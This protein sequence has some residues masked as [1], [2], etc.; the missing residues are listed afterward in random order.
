MTTGKNRLHDI[1]GEQTKRQRA[2]DVALID[3]MMTDQIP[4]RF[5]LT[6]FQLR[7]PVMSLGNGV[8]QS[9]IRR[10]WSLGVIGE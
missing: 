6:G 7:E 5:D 9:R 8:D 2:A 4:D 1:G 3:L 10:S